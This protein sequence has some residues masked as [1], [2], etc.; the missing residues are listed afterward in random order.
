M[1]MR[2]RRAAGRTPLSPGCASSARLSLSLRGL[3]APR[4]CPEAQPGPGRPSRSPSP[5]LSPAASRA[6]HRPR[7]RPAGPGGD[8]GGIR[9]GLPASPRGLVRDLR[10][11]TRPGEGRAAPGRSPAR[12]CR[13]RGG[14]LRHRRRYRCRPS[15]SGR[16]VPRSARARSVPLPGGRLRVR[17]PGCPLPLSFFLPSFLPSLPPAPSPLP[18]FPRRL[19]PAPGAR[20]PPAGPAAVGCPP[21]AARG[22]GGLAGQPPL[23]TG[24]YR[25][26]AARLR[27]SARGSAAAAVPVCLCHVCAWAGGG[28]GPRRSQPV[29]HR[30]ATGARRPTS[31]GLAER[32]PGP[33]HLGP[34]ARVCNCFGDSHDERIAGDV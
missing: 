28:A 25:E 26:P 22:G 15:L 33:P 2:M 6:V 18:A 21:P 10:G 7:R 31:G 16:W 34:A 11:E 4:C 12:R 1:G 20:L 30:P 5:P 27:R 8:G 24:G 9:A 32:R 23:P 19:P 17:V 3:P 13:A 14:F 29:T